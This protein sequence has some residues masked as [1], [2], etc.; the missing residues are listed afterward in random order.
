[1][2]KSKKKNAALTE[3]VI[4]NTKVET[5]VYSSTT[6]TI[7]TKGHLRSFTSLHEEGFAYLADNAYIH[8][9]YR[10]HYNFEQCFY[11]LFQL[12]NETI[13]VW[14]HMIG[15]L[16]FITWG[17]FFLLRLQSEGGGYGLGK[18]ASSLNPYDYFGPAPCDF[19]GM[20]YLS[21]GH[22]TRR[23][24]HSI[25]TTNDN[26]LSTCAPV[27]QTT[28]DSILTRDKILFDQ[29]LTHIPTLEDVQ[30]KLASMPP[31]IGQHLVS[32]KSEVEFLRESLQ[33]ET[34]WLTRESWHQLIRMKAQITHRVGHF[35]EILSQ[36][37]K[38]AEPSILYALEEY[39]MVMGMIQTGLH[40]LDFND[41]THSSSEAEHHVSSWPL[42]VFICR[43]E[44]LCEYVNM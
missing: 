35:Q 5:T 14:T 36:L 33:H 18:V 34:E 40:R 20:K 22:H 21:Q 9:G 41:N 1:M 12:H 26:I 4:E 10:L 16:I 23:M 30:T 17:F 8:T 37:K 44:Y 43:Y 19:V 24:F 2:A 25:I 38:D 13:N 27:H 32:I 7:R 42:V 3:D 28:T 15:A 29:I 6:T 31:T 11:S 39:N